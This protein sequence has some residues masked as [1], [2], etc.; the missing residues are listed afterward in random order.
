MT[1][2]SRIGRHVETVV[3]GETVRAYVPPPLPPE[4]VIDLL[5]LLPR[6]GLAERALLFVRRRLG[7]VGLGQLDRPLGT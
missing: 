2:S 5:S 7:W 6:L 4:P 1:T 3:A